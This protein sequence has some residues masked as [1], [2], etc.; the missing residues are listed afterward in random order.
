MS[1]DRTLD[2]L[3]LDDDLSA[4]VFLLTDNDVVVND[5]DY[6]LIPTMDGDRLFAHHFYGR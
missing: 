2:V 6:S 3:L 1:C 4:A 5:L